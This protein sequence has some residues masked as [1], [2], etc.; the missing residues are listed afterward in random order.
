MKIWYIDKLLPQWKYNSLSFLDYSVILVFV[1]QMWGTVWVYGRVTHYLVSCSLSAYLVPFQ[2]SKCIYHTNVIKSTYPTYTYTY[3]ANSFGWGGSFHL[4][5]LPR[6]SLLFL[7]FSHSFLL[8]Y[9][10]LFDLAYL[11]L[12]IKFC[13]SC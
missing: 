7:L 2:C 9:H 1:L 6:N 11:T 3:T 10:W 12:I 5:N 8:S 4:M 13:A